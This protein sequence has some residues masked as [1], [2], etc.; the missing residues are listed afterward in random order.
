[1]RLMVSVPVVGAG[2]SSEL[3]RT[4]SRSAWKIL[5][6]LIAQGGATGTLLMFASSLAY[7]SHNQTKTDQSRRRRQDL[8]IAAC[9]PHVRGVP[10]L[11]TLCE[12]ERGVARMLWSSTWWGM[13]RG[14][15]EAALGGDEVGL[16]DQPGERSTVLAGSGNK[17]THRQRES[18]REREKERVSASWSPE[19]APWEV[20]S[21]RRHPVR[22]KSSR[23][24]LHPA[25]LQGETSCEPQ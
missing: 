24:F 25:S 13:Q 9:V 18:E 6:H 2:R 17:I 14:R 3:G 5:L 7:C 1:M 11:A 8:R 15:R 16:Q 23:P 22:T 10:R 12:Q 19:P 4:S 21:H 20:Q